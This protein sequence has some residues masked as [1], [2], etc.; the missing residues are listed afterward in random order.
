MSL[1]V[2]CCCFILLNLQAD[3]EL[4]FF[5]KQLEKIKSIPVEDSVS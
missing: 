3:S 5:D 1:L 2:L 4:I